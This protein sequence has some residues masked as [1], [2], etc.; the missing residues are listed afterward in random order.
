MTNDECRLRAEL[1]GGDG[2][3]HDDAMY[4]NAM[5]GTRGHTGGLWDYDLS[6]ERPRQ[7]YFTDVSSECLML[8]ACV[9]WLLLL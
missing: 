3:E 8:A 5:N 9:T 6:S 1:R 7:A 4:C 2:M